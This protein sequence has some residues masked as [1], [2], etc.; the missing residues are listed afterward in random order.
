MRQ[1]PILSC[2]HD[3]VEE[4]AVGCR[5]YCSPKFK[6]FLVF[7]CFL[8]LANEANLLQSICAVKLVPE[9]R[10]LSA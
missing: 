10:E 1:I 3:I 5:R 4:G 2:S 9:T 8:P 7:Q 6:A